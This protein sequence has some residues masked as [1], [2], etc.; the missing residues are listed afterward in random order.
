VAERRQTAQKQSA[1]RVKLASILLRSDLTLGHAV[2]RGKLRQ[3]Q[4]SGTTRASSSRIHGK[5]AN[6]TGVTKTPG[7][8]ELPK[9]V[10]ATAQATSTRS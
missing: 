4:V 2:A 3:F 8:P 7:G 1:V 6:R 5:S 10:I 9:Q